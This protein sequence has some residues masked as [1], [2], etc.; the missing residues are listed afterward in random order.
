MVLIT[1]N[2]TLPSSL[3]AAVLSLS[4]IIRY[5]RSRSEIVTSSSIEE[6]PVGPD[7]RSAAVTVTRSVR[8]SSPASACRH[9][10]TSSGTLNIE[11]VGIG[12]SAPCP[13]SWPVSTSAAY[14]QP[15]TPAARNSWSKAGV[16]MPASRACG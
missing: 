5:A 14:S 12:S 10:A 4:A 13:R 8:S 16:L 3:S 15:V 2:P 7:T 6:I 11:A 1:S 9:S